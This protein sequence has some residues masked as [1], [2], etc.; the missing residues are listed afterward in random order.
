[1]KPFKLFY[2]EMTSAA[3]GGAP[4]NNASVTAGVD[5]FTPDTIG[6]PTSKR[7]PKI[8]KRG[9]HNDQDTSPKKVV[10]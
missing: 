3:L 5:G 1:M 9:E 2:E 6:V 7:K 8:L 4:A 10:L